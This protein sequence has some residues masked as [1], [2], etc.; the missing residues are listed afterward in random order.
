MDPKNPTQPTHEEDIAF[1][2]AERAMGRSAMRVIELFEG[3]PE[4]GDD[5]FD[6]AGEL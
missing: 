1:R 5:H 2:D 6:F 4:Q 3:M